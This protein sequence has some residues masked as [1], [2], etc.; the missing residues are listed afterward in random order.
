MSAL[1]IGFEALAFTF[2]LLP[3]V[4]AIAYLL[5]CREERKIPTPL[6]YA[7]ALGQLTGAKREAYKM[8][9]SALLETSK[10][11]AGALLP[12]KTSTFPTKAPREIFP[13]GQGLLDASSL[14][15]SLEDRMSDTFPDLRDGNVELQQEDIEFG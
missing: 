8:T 7:K 11:T 10:M 9:A 3:I 1:L 12:G 6:G 13:L 14:L 2:A 5:G 4:A 15:E